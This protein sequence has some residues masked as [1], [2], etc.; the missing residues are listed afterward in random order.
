MGL[1][2]WSEPR[3]DLIMGT[4]ILIAAGCLIAMARAGYRA[5]VDLPTITHPE[6]RAP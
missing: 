2:H 1:R 6:R 4:L 5:W 3:R